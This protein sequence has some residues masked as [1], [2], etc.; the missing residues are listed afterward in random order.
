MADIGAMS[1]RLNDSVS[2]AM[3]QI[4]SPMPIGKARLSDVHTDTLPTLD[5]GQLV[6]VLHELGDGANTDKLSA[7]FDKVFS[8]S[9]SGLEKD[10]ATELLGK[11]AIELEGSN[12]VS[13]GPMSRT[14]V[15]DLINTLFVEQRER[16]QNLR[17]ELLPLITVIALVAYEIRNQGIDISYQRELLEA[18]ST[19][20][21]NLAA[22][23]LINNKDTQHIAHEAANQLGEVLSANAV[24]DK[25]EGYLDDTLGKLADQVAKKIEQM[26]QNQ[27]GSDINSDRTMEQAGHNIASL[28]GSL[29]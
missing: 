29:S 10:L 26:T 18:V 13:T 16:E 20:A 23:A 2:S 22:L 5:K 21:E 7:G 11:M 14:E 25:D 19:V 8:P 3:A 6:G 1:P 15:M 28:T 9:L 12:S 4:S 17:A 24:D 27:L